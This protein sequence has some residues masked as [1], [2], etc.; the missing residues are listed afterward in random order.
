MQNLLHILSVLLALIIQH[1]RRMR[2]IMSS[3][4]CQNLSNFSA[5]SHER[6]DFWN[7]VTEHKMRVLIFSTAFI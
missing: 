4:A 5:L 2:R 3:V 7:K 6:Q 1:A